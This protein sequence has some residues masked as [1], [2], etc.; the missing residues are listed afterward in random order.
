MLISMIYKIP[1]Y[2]ASNYLEGDKT[3]FSGEEKEAIFFLSQKVIPT[4]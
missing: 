3:D 2:I 4:L 1:N